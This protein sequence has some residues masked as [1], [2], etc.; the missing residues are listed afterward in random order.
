MIR[1]ILEYAVQSWCP[2]LEKDIDELEKIQHKITKLVPWF[3]DLPYDKRC[4]R[5][6][7][8]SFKDRR[9]GG[10]SEVY[11][12]LRGDEG[13]NYTKFFK[14]SENTTRGHKLKLDK[15]KHHKSSMRGGWFAIRVINPWNNLL[16]HVIEAPSIAAF[17][18]HLDKHLGF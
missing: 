17:K 15:R 1:P 10:T 6:K 3:Q 13:S 18:A 7:L 14:L 5:L 9:K 16:A 2:N 4:R 12:I 11:K 8:P